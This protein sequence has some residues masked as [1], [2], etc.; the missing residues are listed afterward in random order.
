[1]KPS[2]RPLARYL[3]LTLPILLCLGLGAQ[4]TAVLF[5]FLGGT[6]ILLFDLITLSFTCW[7]TVPWLLYGAMGVFIIANIYLLIRLLGR[8]PKKYK[9]HWLDILASLVCLS[10]PGWANLSCALKED[11]SV[12]THLFYGYFT[13]FNLCVL[14][15]ICFPRS[16]RYFF[17]RSDNNKE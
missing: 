4:T 1:M 2:N 10:F 14:C 16:H 11:C 3:Q 9:K 15:L 12:R 5:H 8:W 17:K 13:L 6:I 7:H